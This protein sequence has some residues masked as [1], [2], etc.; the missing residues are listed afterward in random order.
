MPMTRLTVEGCW[1]LVGEIGYDDVS[2]GRRDDGDGRGLKC[3]LYGAYDA[4]LSVER[5]PLPPPGWADEQ[6][7]LS[8]ALAQVGVGLDLGTPGAGTELHPCW[9]DALWSWAAPEMGLSHRGVIWFE[10]LEMVNGPVVLK[11]RLPLLGSGG[12]RVLS[13]ND[14][15]R[16]AL[17]SN[18]LRINLREYVW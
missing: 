11:A 9:G 8:A 15:V 17:S 3:T 5:L 4:S 16:E 7:L 2:L 13:P 14:A 6:E 12:E 10:N 1:I 18:G